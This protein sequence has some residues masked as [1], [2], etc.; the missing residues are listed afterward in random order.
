[1]TGKSTLNHYRIYLLTIWV[2][3]GH[4]HEGS[5]TWRFRL[6]DPRSG[7][8]RCFANLTELIVGLHTELIETQQDASDELNE[9]R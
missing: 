1:M 2:E 6:Q 3:Q 7:K 9:P 5:D 8:Q 4:D